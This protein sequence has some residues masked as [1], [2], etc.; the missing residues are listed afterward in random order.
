MVDVPAD[1]DARQAIGQDDFSRVD[2]SHSSDHLVTL[3]RSMLRADWTQRITADAILQHTVVRPL[4]Q[5]TKSYE[6]R[7]PSINLSIDARWVSEIDGRLRGATIE[8]R[9]E[10]MPDLFALAFTR[11]KDTNPRYDDSA[12]A[13]SH[14]QDDAMDVDA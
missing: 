14:S 4:V 5:L 10:F 13:M 2:L 11:R 12:L 9:P 3:I 8:E 6:Q 7:D 1:G